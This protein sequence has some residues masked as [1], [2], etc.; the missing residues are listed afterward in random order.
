[1]AQVFDIKTK[2][3]LVPDLTDRVYIA[4]IEK[5]DKLEL[6]QEMVDFQ[7]LRAKQ[8]LTV[9]MMVK[10]ISLFEM[11]MLQSETE[12]LRLIT[13]NYCSSLKT[14][15]EKYKKHWANA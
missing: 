1:M 13:K 8:G 12:E 3:L 11:L 5:M 9:N 10:G 15:L 14:D 7:E 2:K 4:K 6:L